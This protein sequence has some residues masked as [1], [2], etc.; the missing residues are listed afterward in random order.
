M[1]ARAIFDLR[2]WVEGVDNL[3]VWAKVTAL[4][5]AAQL[6]APPGCDVRY[7]QLRNPDKTRNFRATMGPAARRKR[8]A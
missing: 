2:V 6:L 5:R 7:V 1:T 8:A 3:D 4:Q